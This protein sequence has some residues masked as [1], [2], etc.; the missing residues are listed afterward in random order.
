MKNALTWA[1]VL[2]LP[3]A[4]VAAVLWINTQA[5]IGWHRSSQLES[6][7]ILAAGQILEVTEFKSLK[8]YASYQASFRFQTSAQTEIVTMERPV[9]DALARR[10]KANAEAQVLYLPDDPESAD[11]QG[12][13]AYWSNIWLAAAIDIA[14]VALLM[15]GMRRQ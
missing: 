12:N 3:I 5:L 9:D 7:G 10:L 1:L 14:I 8:T 11:L 4:L 2:T 6:R 15:L 13:S